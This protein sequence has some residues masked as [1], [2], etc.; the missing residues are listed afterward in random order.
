MD[1]MNQ[2]T[3]TDLYNKHIF[4]LDNI[5]SHDEC[6]TLIEKTNN[7]GW[8]KSSPSGGGHGRTGNEDARTNK[9]CVLFDEILANQIWN[10]VKIF[11]PDDLSFVGENVYFNSITKGEEWKPSYIYNKFRIYKYDIGDAFP[12]HIDY[13]VKRNIIKDN[14]E[15]VEQSFLTLLIY[16]NDDFEGGETGYWPDH[17]GIHCRFLRNVERCSNK[18]DHQIIIKP[19]TGMCVVQ[20]Q[21]ILHEGLPPTKGI[22]YILRTDIIHQR[23]VIRN[24]YTKID[25]SKDKTGEWERLFETSCKNYAD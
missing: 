3:Y 4:T 13:K 2:N 11:L 14:K 5:L 22:K 16:L 18:K 8:N 21:N 24:K 15:F 17:N 19:Q 25:L 10:Q 23:E 12:E 6:S 1:Y 9:F 20:D 7:I